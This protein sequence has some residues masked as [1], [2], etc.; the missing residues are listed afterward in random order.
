MLQDSLYYLDVD[1]SE[2][3]S[4]V[5]VKQLVLAL[6]ENRLATL[7][8]Q[9]KFEE[10]EAF[11]REFDLDPEVRWGRLTSAWRE[12]IIELIMLYTNHGRFALA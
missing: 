4:V 10:A 6:P 12:C 8:N 3:A 1:E 11:A 7:L 5:V 2:E 9:Q